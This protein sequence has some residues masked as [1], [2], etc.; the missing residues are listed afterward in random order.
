ML[1][2]TEELHDCSHRG[3][4]CADFAKRKHQT[5]QTYLQINFISSVHPNRKKI[6]FNLSSYARSRH[7]ASLAGSVVITV[8]DV[9]FVFNVLPAII[10][11]IVFVLVSVGL[12]IPF[13]IVPRGACNVT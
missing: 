5:T 8:T 13:A 7:K 1:S 12:A 11:A 3:G 9:P 4:F 10:T 2:C 6:V